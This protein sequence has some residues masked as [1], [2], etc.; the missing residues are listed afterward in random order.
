MA[1]TDAL[2]DLISD[3]RISPQLAMKILANFDK[4]IAEVLNEKVKATLQ[5]KVRLL[6]YTHPDN[7]WQCRVSERNRT[8]QEW[9][10]FRRWT[11]C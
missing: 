1:L 7:P 10:A 11:G 6:V 4:S 2:D 8:L 9:T 5:F 3:F